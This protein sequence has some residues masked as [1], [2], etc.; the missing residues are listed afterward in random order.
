M[1]IPGVQPFRRY[2]AF[3]F[4]CSFPESIISLQNL[5][6]SRY[7]A[8]LTSPEMCLK[9]KPF[10][11]ILTSTSFQD[12]CAVIVNE[13]H[14]IAQWGGDFRTAYSEIR[15][16]HAFFP[17]HIPILA[18]LAT[19]T[20]SALQE[21]HSQLSIN[22]DDCF[23]L[24][25]GNDHPNIAYS[26]LPINSAINYDF[27]LPLLTS[28]QQPS[29]P[30]NIIKSLIFVNKVLPA[31][32]TARAIQAWLPKHLHKYVN[33]MHAHCTPKARQHAIRQFRQGK[34]RVLIMV[35]LEGGCAVSRMSHTVSRKYHFIND[36]SPSASLTVKMNSARSL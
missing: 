16:L 14:C 35:I 25:H 34:T 4:C 33:Y 18:T 12:I 2:N 9:H 1:E 13:A 19:L 26:V 31:Q 17:P 30:N 20:L 21:V 3:F 23:F 32:L 6:D 10:R 36:H 24:N 28:K 7:K 5:K 29:T 22:I 8:I 15:K 27:L 11:N